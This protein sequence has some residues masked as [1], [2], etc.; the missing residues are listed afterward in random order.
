MSLL[1]AAWVQ[2][3]NINVKSREISF[4]YDV[5]SFG[6]HEKCF[7]LGHIKLFDANS[8]TPGDVI[9]I[10]DYDCAHISRKCCQR[11]AIN[12]FDDLVPS[13]NKPLPQPILNQV[14]VAI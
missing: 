7:V 11:N 14:Y 4:V 10:T 3:A 2:Q 5:R 13:G 12:T 9:V 8:L 1:P 6:F